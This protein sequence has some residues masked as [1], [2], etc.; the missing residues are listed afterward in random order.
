MKK[1]IQFT[2]FILL[3][4]ALFLGCATP[5]IWK[6]NPSIQRAENKYFFAQIAS[7]GNEM[8]YD[9]FY[10][11]IKNR[12]DKDLKIDW[13]K[14]FYIRGGQKSGGFM[15]EGVDPKERHNSRPPDIIP[16]RG[17]ISKTIWPVDL[18]T[19][20]EHMK[21][22]EGENGIYLSIMVDGEEI[23]E[24]IAVDLYRGTK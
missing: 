20:L 1:E 10:L 3:A 12:T 24:E 13:D 6:S 9:A 22:G 14:T 2:L 7:V 5:K 4:I 23:N 8:G 18:A 15:F 19:D 16:P 17:Y 11:Y 21:M